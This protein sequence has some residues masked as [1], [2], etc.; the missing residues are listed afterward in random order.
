[1][2]EWGRKQYAKPWPSRAHVWTWGAFFLSCLFF[3]FM[4]WRD[5]RVNWTA[6]ERLYLSDYLKSGAR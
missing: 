1:M 6:A 2:A 5:G 4:T 3:V